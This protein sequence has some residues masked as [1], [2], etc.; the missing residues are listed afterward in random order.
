MRTKDWVWLALLIGTILFTMAVK[1][2]PYFPGDVS[3]TRFA[4]TMAPVS[5]GWAQRVTAT[6][7]S[8]GT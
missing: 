4:Q 7:N 8:P 3:V 1:R 2:P 6:A 5:T